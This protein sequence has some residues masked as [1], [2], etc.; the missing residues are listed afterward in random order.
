[1]RLRLC[2]LISIP[3]FMW[4]G[5][6]AIAQRDFS[7]VVVDAQDL[8]HGL[9]MLSSRG[10]NIGLSIGDDGVF[11]VDD[12]F[13]PLSEKI[14]EKIN[15]LGGGPV[16]YVINTHWHGD[17]T[18]GNENFSAIGAHIV[19]H[20]NVRKRL[21]TKQFIKAIEAEVEP[22]PDE[23]LPDITYRSTMSFHLNGEEARIIH[24]PNG[25]T[26]GDSLILFEDAKVIHMG[27]M[28]FNGNYPFIDTS[29]GGGV[30]GVIAAA[31]QALAMIDD[32]WSIIPGHGPLATKRD[33]AAYHDMLVTVRARIKARRDKGETLEEIIAADPL[34]DF[35]EK[36]GQ[37][38]IT[39]ERIITPVYESL[40][41]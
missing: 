41:D 38:F 19:A 25:H 36:W 3:L 40:A 11:I 37:G 18:G 39:A 6:S 22:R 34:A 30:N 7:D 32:R 35:N 4:S 15:E 16:D 17:H 27:D 23:A 8:G 13:A 31:E 2:S 14:T 28:F 26:D 24:A 12:Q 21:S 1:M 5:T 33:L 29:S 9:Y 10:G 20:E